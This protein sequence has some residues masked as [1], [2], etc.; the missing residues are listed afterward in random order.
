MHGIILRDDF[1]RTI[2]SHMYIDKGSETVGYCSRFKHSPPRHKLFF[3]QACRARYHWCDD[4]LLRQCCRRAIIGPSTIKF[5]KFCHVEF[6][7]VSGVFSMDCVCLTLP[8]AALWTMMIPPFKTTEALPHLLMFGVHRG[9]TVSD[10]S[11]AD[12]HSWWKGWIIMNF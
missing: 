10:I 1:T 12:G 11:L 4:P 6:L 2:T 9:Q 8:L 3:A 5:I 7:G